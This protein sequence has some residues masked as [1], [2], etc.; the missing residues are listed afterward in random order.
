M[1]QLAISTFECALNQVDSIR[2]RLQEAGLDP[3][4]DIES[5]H[6]A[7]TG[8]RKWIILNDRI[9]TAICFEEQREGKLMATVLGD[10]KL[11]SRALNIE[12]R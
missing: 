10:L 11:V 3:R 6:A 4:I 7:P 2:H 5:T 9:P 12:L 8:S 1:G